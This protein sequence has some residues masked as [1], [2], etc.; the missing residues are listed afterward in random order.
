MEYLSFQRACVFQPNVVQQFE[1]R[2]SFGRVFVTNQKLW[3]SNN[4]RN[5][6]SAQSTCIPLSAGFITSIVSLMGPYF[7]C[8]FS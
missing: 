5:K 6:H 7:C 2:V 3:C 1:T 8:W 4:D